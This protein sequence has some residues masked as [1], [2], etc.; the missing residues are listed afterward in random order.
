MGLTPEPRGK[1]TI[2]GGEWRITIALD[3]DGSETDCGTLRW[4]DS[5]VARSPTEFGRLIAG[6]VEERAEKFLPRKRGSQQRK[7]RV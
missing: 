3:V 4:S 7:P 1:R 5:F 2:K 6:A